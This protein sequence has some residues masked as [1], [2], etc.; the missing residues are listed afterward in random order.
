MSKQGYCSLCQHPKKL[1]LNDKIAAGK[2]FTVALREM[3]EF[4]M[5]FSKTTFLTHKGHITSPLIT[6]VEEARANPV[7]APKNNRAV[8]EM[9]RDLG[10]RKAMENPEEVTVKDALKAASILQQ[11]E[12]K[13]ENILVILAKAVMQPSLEIIEGDYKELN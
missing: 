11:A 6:A 1:I 5:S 2:G 3:D 9:I 7:I 10:A 8:L 4:G 13:Q 12:G